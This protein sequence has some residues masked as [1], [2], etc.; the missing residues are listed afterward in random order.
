MKSTRAVASAGDGRFVRP[1]TALV[2][3]ERE[4]AAAQEPL[5]RCIVQQRVDGRI[6]SYAAVATDGGLRGAVVSRYVRTWPPAAGSVS[7]SETIAAPP[8]LHRRVAALI[9]A[10]GWRGIFELELI[11]RP[12]GGLG[13]IDLNPRPYGSMAL[14]VAAG[15]P[16]PAIWCATVLGRPVPSAEA[17]IG[18]RYRWEDA[19]VRSLL[20]RARSGETAAALAGLRP[21]HG[22]AHAYF[23][24]TDPLPGFTRLAQMGRHVLAGRGA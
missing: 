21:R 14:A 4:L 12:D 22:V 13:A 23:Q 1:P 3:D 6:V 18:V 7:F 16:L 17:R 8:E 24:R 20:A 2:A 11:E 19:D 9:E 5:G 10:L 15:S